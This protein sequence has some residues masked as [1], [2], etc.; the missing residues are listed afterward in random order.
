MY[1][2]IM[3]LRVLKVN[4]WVKDLTRKSVTKHVIII[5]T[6]CTCIKLL[7]CKKKKQQKS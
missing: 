2:E 1:I 4:G 6:K 5:Y 3:L 7:I